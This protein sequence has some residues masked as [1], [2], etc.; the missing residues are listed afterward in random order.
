MKTA[1]IVTILMA[2][3]A[4]SPGAGAAEVAR[5][6]FSHGPGNCQ[7]ALPVFDGNIRKRPKAIA[8]EGSSVAF[9]TCDFEAAPEFPGKVELIAVFITNRSNGAALVN[10]TGVF[11]VADETY[12]PSITK[13]LG[14]APGDTEPLAWIAGVDNGG[15]YFSFPALSCALPP[16]TEISGTRLR[17]L[18]EIGN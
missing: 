2:L 11:G 13:S 5:M 6:S 1:M 7:A 10:C 18:E 16:G 12:S 8:N 15:T 9:I 14:L 3:S 4:T 17:Y